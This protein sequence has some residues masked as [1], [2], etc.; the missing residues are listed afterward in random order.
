[1]VILT[2]VHRTESPE[3]GEIADVALDGR[4]SE[5]I[6]RMKSVGALLPNPRSLVIAHTNAMCIAVNEKRMEEEIRDGGKEVVAEVQMKVGRAKLYRGLPVVVQQTFH[7]YTATTTTTTTTTGEGVVVMAAGGSDERSSRR[8]GSSSRRR[9]TKNDDVD[10]EC[11]SGRDVDSDDDAIVESDE[12]NEKDSEVEE[13]E[14]EDE[15]VEQ[16]VPRPAEAKSYYNSDRGVVTDIDVE[17]KTVTLEIR[18]HTRERDP[19]TREWRRIVQKTTHVVTFEDLKNR[20]GVAYCVTVHRVQ[21]ATIDEP[22]MIVELDSMPNNLAYTAI[23]RT[24]ALEHLHVPDATL[25]TELNV[26]KHEVLTTGDEAFLAEARKR[27]EGYRRQDAENPRLDMS[28][29]LKKDYI[30]ATDLLAMWHECDGICG[31]C[32]QAMRVRSASRVDGAAVSATAAAAATEPSTS[33][34]PATV[35]ALWTADRIDNALPHLRDNVRLRCH[36]CNSS[37]RGR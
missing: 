7:A 27:V 8:K 20:F 19:T 18:S 23:T 21:G 15:E 6:A 28:K 24:K 29:V 4:K 11:D 12:D 30:S 35:G 31:G 10:S 32:G 26:R 2:K 9:S 3:V 25:S 34:A 13:E 14:D 16:R 1:M 37:R 5:A 17:A 36:Q 22:Y 33:K